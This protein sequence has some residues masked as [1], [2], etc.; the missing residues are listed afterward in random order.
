MTIRD[1]HAPV[2]ARHRIAE[3]IVTD[4]LI[5]EQPHAEPVVRPTRTGMIWLPG[6]TFRMGSDQHYLE[7]APVHRVSVAGFFT[8]ILPFTSSAPLGLA[9]SHILLPI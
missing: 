1:A 8:C 4:H 7:E 3:A 2:A 6:G 9:K 5:A